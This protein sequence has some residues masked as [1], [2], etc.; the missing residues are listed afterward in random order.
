M[1]DVISAVAVPLLAAVQ[2]AGP[3][4][5]GFIAAVA[6]WDYLGFTLALLGLIAVLMATHHLLERRRLFRLP[7]IGI[8]LIMLGITFG[9]I[10]AVVAALPGDNEEL[11]NILGI[12]LGAALAFSSTTFI[13]NGLAGLMLRVVRPFEIGDW[14]QVG[15]HFG[16]I[17]ERGLF[18]TLIQTEHLDL[19]TLPNLYLTSHPFTVIP[20]RDRVSR[21]GKVRRP[22]TRVS[23]DVSLGYEANHSQ[24]EQLLRDAAERCGLDEARVH[25]LDLGDFTVAYRVAGVTDEVERLLGVRSRLRQEIIDTLHGADIEI[26]SPTLMNTRAYDSDWRFMAKPSREM[27]QQVQSPVERE[28]VDLPEVVEAKELDTRRIELEQKIET[29]RKQVKGAEGAEEER[30]H[31]RLERAEGQL[32][33]LRG[34]ASTEEPAD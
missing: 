18:H 4:R 24:V 13:G 32:D 17:L 5:G 34:E 14:L 19:T 27:D 8:Q 26:A 6:G 23:A 22:G 25:I 2:A 29:L 16:A 30:L 12:V 15:D 28:Q 11:L 21:S 10:L 33:A 20:A 9:G 3:E 1:P 7:A 31:A